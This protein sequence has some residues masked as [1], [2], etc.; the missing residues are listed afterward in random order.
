MSYTLVQDQLE[1]NRFELENKYEVINTSHRKANEELLDYL[2]NHFEI[3]DDTV[4]VTNSDFGHGYSKKTFS[5]F[6]EALRIKKHE[7]FWDAYHVTEK[8]KQF[9]RYYPTE[10]EEKIFEAIKKHSN[11]LIY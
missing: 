2:Y 4:L 3:T 1:K 8:I 10:L 6:R 5:E 9:F 11:N 7:H